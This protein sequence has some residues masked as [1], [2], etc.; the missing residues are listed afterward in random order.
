MDLD[1][2][3]F[4]EMIV[5]TT[6]TFAVLLGLARFLGKEQ[7]SQ[8]TFFNYITGITIGSIAGEVVAHD[9]THYFNAIT[10]LIWWSI[11]TLIV[12]Y[13]SLKS[14]K[15]KSL[16]DDKPMIVIKNGKILE[17]ELKKSRLPIGD[18]NMLLRIQGIFS[19]KDVHFAVLETN[20][21]LSVF[22][23]VAQQSATKQDVKAQIV[24]PKYMPCTI[25]AEGKIITQNLKEAGITEEWVMKQLKKHGV[26]SIQQ[27]FY[28]EIESDGT[29]Y[30]DL[31]ED[32]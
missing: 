31:K 19:V 15:A 2:Y 11:L 16:L 7:L 8:L 9:D 17:H 3:S 24:V 25:I 13:I 1:N 30:M 28:A 21:E 6:V 12:S 32:D 18:L 27:V 23:K 22:K 14:A 26:N 29:V 4:L 20:G 5:R 10:S